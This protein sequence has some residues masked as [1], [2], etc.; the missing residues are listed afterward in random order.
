MFWHPSWPSCM[1]NTLQDSK[2]TR[3]NFSQIRYLCCPC[4]LSMGRLHLI[5]LVRTLRTPLTSNVSVPYVTYDTVLPRVKRKVSY[6]LFLLLWK[7][8]CPDKCKLK[9]K[10]IILAHDSRYSPSWWGSSGCNLNWSNWLH[11]FL[12]STQLVLHFVWFRISV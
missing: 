2:E 10:E 8:K 11:P 12:A 3:R 5:N 1:T 6:F 9:K 7:K 4:L